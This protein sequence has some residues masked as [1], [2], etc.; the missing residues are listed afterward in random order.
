MSP[1]YMAFP[2]AVVLGAA[3]GVMAQSGADALPVRLSSSFGTGQLRFPR[4]VAEMSSAGEY[5]FP[6]E[7]TSAS[8]VLIER[9]ES[10]CSACAS[11][12]TEPETVEPGAKGRVVVRIQSLRGSGAPIV[13]KVFTVEQ[14]GSHEYELQLIANRAQAWSSAARAQA[15][16]ARRTEVDLQPRKELFIGSWTASETKAWVDPKEGD[17][18]VGEDEL[19][20][21]GKEEFPTGETVLS[22]DPTGSFHLRAGLRKAAGT[23]EVQGPLLLLHLRHQDCPACDKTWPLELVS[24]EDGHLVLDL[25]DEDDGSPLLLRLTFSKSNPQP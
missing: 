25:P 20:S 2:G 6:F 17:A 12:L 3:C 8:P 15:R 7:N 5:D 19:A 11:F 13:G 4:T 1:R 18:P 14:N 24:V 23:W 22:I 16:L 10:G 21:Y 9:T